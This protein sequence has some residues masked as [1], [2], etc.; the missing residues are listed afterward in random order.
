MEDNNNINLGA[1]PE[2]NSNNNAC[3][4]NENSVPDMYEGAAPDETAD[5]FDNSDSFFISGSPKENGIETEEDIIKAIKKEK[6]AK[7][8][9]KSRKKLIKTLVWILVI[10]FLSVGIASAVII[11]TGEYLGI[12]PGR[13][14]DVVVEIEKGM[15]TKQIAAQLKKSGAINSEIAFRLYSKVKGLDSK[16]S[17][18]VYTFNNEKGYEDLAEM[19]MKEGAKADSVSVMIPEM[20][21]IDDMAKILEEKG[22]CTAEDFKNEVNYGEFNNSFIEDL[23]TEKVYY[24]FEG[25]LFPDTYDFYCYDSKACAHL[26][27]QKMLDKMEEEFDSKNIEKAKSMGYSIHEILTMASIVELE[28]GSSP[29]EMANV[30]QVFYNRLASSDFS[31]LGSSPTRKYPYGNGRYNTYE[32]VGLPVGP[33]CAPS[34][35][36]IEAAL[37]PNTEQ[38]ATYFVT[39]KNMNFYYNTSLSAHNATIAKLQREN[40][41]IYED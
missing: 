2:E 34:H 28:A 35:K 17:Y 36:S 39:D 8:R 40:N 26:A 7:K 9:S 29:N 30:A 20:S 21:T 18:G 38:K 14:K 23:P 25:Y 22:V 12:G 11:G 6:H 13:G 27:V 33:L 3:D 31:T 32:C 37:N 16:F 41:W 19:L 5:S 4:T 24:R 15:S 1:N 10:V